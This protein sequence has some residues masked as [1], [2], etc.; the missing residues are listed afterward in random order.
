MLKQET[1]SE[2]LMEVSAYMKGIDVAECIELLDRLLASTQLPPELRGISQRYPQAIDMIFDKDA[3]HAEV[4]TGIA[5][6]LRIEPIFRMILMIS[7]PDEYESVTKQKKGFAYVI[8]KLGVNAKN[9]DL[10]RPREYYAGMG[11]CIEQIAVSYQLRNVE[12]HTCE[13]WGRREMYE[14]IDCVL[15]SYL[16]AIHLK[17]DKI[18]RWLDGN[19][20]GTIDV[21]EYMDEII[22]YFKDKMK[23]FI[24][25]NG[26]E[27][28]QVVNRYVTENISKKNMSLD[29]MENDADEDME[30]AAG[31]KGTIDDL[32]KNSVPENQMVIW[33]EAGT[34]KSTTLEYLAYLDAVDWKKNHQN[35]IPVLIP[36][37]V[38]SKDIS[39]KSY[40]AMKLRVSESEAVTLLQ[41]GQ[42]HLFL[43]GV[44]EIPNEF[45]SQ[46]RAVRLREIKELLEQ[47]KDCFTIITNR[48][49]E[50]NSFKNVPVFNLIKLNNEQLIMF[51]Q[52][53]TENHET[54]KLITE[55]IGEN[56]RLRS[57]VR[58]PLMFSRLI[59]IVDA[60]GEIPN[61]EGKIIGVFLDTLLS[62]ERYDKLDANFD[63]KKANYLLRS[64][65]YNG[66]EN[67]STNSGMT[68]EQVLDYMNKCM[69]TYCFTIDAFYMLDMLIQLGILQKRDEL[70]LFAHQA[71]QDY[72]HALEE[73]AVLGI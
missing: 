13:L 50:G 56:E 65:A 67:S 54:I 37:G 44:N 7:D 59:D 34:G 39:L 35:S 33:G 48:P 27:N 36:L 40:I 24:L 69:H 64:I 12:A 61:S 46:L 58:T 38:V 15:V 19:S 9:V 32:R 55:A 18:K 5:T 68:E 53:N 21:T 3:T 20:S 51:L 29:K 57:V 62:R 16:Y 4:I 42:L 17:R 1:K 10:D 66:L 71:Y 70:Y 49:D 73:L 31:R 41:N 6:A 22:T 45:S 60:T 14:N 11:K 8:R 43:D 52:K 26:E 25:L 72:Y 30:E 47:Y 63:V 28:L 2:I 23:K